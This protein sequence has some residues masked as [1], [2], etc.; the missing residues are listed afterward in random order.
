MYTSWRK[1]LKQQQCKETY[2]VKESTL[3]TDIQQRHALNIQQTHCEGINIYC[4]G[5]F[6]IKQRSTYFVKFVKT[7]YKR[8][9]HHEEIFSY[10]RDI[11]S[12][13]N[14][15]ALW[16]IPSDVS[17]IQHFQRSVPRWLADP[18]I[19]LQVV[20]H[21]SREVPLQWR[22]GRSITSTQQALGN[23]S[24]A[25]RLHEITWQ[26][27][28]WGQ[29]ACLVWGAAQRGRF[30]KHH[31]DS[32]G[33]LLVHQTENQG[34]DD[35][36]THPR[37]QSYRQHHPD[38]HREQGHHEKTAHIHAKHVQKSHQAVL[39]GHWVATSLSPVPKI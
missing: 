32:S 30:G 39:K 33:T 23:S 1:L 3:T 19:R 27:H 31:G 38:V 15:R 13:G 5:I 36:V 6:R 18:V 24:L 25:Q 20:R 2:I 21:I 4:E 26:G 29:S 12:E 8:N 28:M 14:C 16:G 34:A 10:N 22:I 11:H 37:G 9:V 35:Q 7:S 17:Y